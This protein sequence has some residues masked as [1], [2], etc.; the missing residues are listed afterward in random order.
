MTAPILTNFPASQVETLPN[1]VARAVLRAA[2]AAENTAH[3]QLGWDNTMPM[4]FQFLQMADPGGTLAAAPVP[5]CILDTGTMT[6]KTRWLAHTL[7]TS[8]PLRDHVMRPPG[9]YL[10]TGMIHEA[11]LTLTPHSSARRVEARL[12]I[13]YLADGTRFAVRRLRGNEPVMDL[14]PAP[15]M[16]MIGAEAGIDESLRDLNSVFNSLREGG[17]PPARSRQ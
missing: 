15:T 16:L 14:T 13:G 3:T 4:L 5:I 2:L 12:L 1:G 7:L 11:W 6:A 9:S 8:K 17:I 10:G